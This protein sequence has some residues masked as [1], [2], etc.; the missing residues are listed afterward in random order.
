MKEIAFGP[1]IKKINELIIKRANKD[2]AQF[3]L[4]LQQAQFLGYL[5]ENTGKPITQRDIEQ[6][7]NVSHPTA[8]GLVKRL[9]E[10]GLIDVTQSIEDRR[11]H[12]LTLTQKDEHIYQQ[13][14]KFRNQLEASLLKDISEEDQ[15]HLFRL[16]C[17][18]S[19]NLSQQE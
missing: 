15:E 10:K 13:S 3:G 4:T 8:S 17:Q 18:M 7:F 14:R 5:R 2:L 16:L 6:H 12:L 11:K 9:A 1:E 19:A